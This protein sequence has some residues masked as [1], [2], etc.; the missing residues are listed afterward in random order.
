MTGAFVAYGHAGFEVGQTDRTV[1]QM[2]SGPIRIAPDVGGFEG[3]L[4]SPRVEQPRTTSGTGGSAVEYAAAA[5]TTAAALIAVANTMLH[6]LRRTIRAYLG[7]GEGASF[8]TSQKCHGEAR[9]GDVGLPLGGQERRG[10]VPA[11]A[12]ASRASH[13]QRMANRG[14]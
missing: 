13:S 2:I 5:V 12:P 8:E 9:H 7:G 14:S 1:G 4:E 3:R 6:G 10:V 11:A